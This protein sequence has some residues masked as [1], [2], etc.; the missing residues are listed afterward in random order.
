[1]LTEPLT[2][3]VGHSPGLSVPLHVPL[4]TIAEARAALPAGCYQR[5]R[6]R[7]AMSVTR[8]VAAYLAML[9][10]LVWVRSVWL[11]VP[12]VLCAGLCVTAMFILGHDAS[13]QA[14][15]TSERINRAVARVLMLP[16]LHLESAWNLGHNRIHHG[17]T[18][19][20]GMDFVWQPLS[21]DDYAV[22]QSGGR[23]ASS[24]TH[25]RCWLRP[26]A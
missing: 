13:H 17:Y 19:R 9:S 3:T 25:R 10:A 8:D 5:S 4:P 2:E 16:S 14:L 7:S 22:R 24:C 6:V 20:R 15:F 11:T 23:V 26:P 21:V 12:L 1:M 18:A